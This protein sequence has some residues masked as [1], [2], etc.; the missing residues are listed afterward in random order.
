M[1]NQNDDLSAVAQLIENMIGKNPHNRELLSAFK[2][3]IIE[4]IRLVEGLELKAA[5]PPK[6]DGTKL[7]AGVP[8]IKQAALFYHDDPWNEIALSMIPVIQQGFPDLKD[9]LD[10]LETFIK[11][12]NIDLFDC[13]KSYPEGGSEIVDRWTA[14]MQLQ[15]PAIAFLI[16][17]VT[18]IIL[19]KRSKQIDW[20][21][22]EWEKGY[23]P[24]CGAFPSIAMIKEK[25]AVRWL[26]CSACG[27]DW[28]FDRFLCPY[29][30]H[31]GHKEVSYFFIEGKEQESAFICDTCKRYLVTLNRV[32]D[33]N[34]RDLDI[35]AIALIHMDVMM[36][37]KGF[38]PMATCE[39]NVF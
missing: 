6:I 14:E 12:G 31:E 20:Q 7:K 17:S 29:C 38:R 9:D 36:Q 15:A 19:E 25:I 24:V 28:K 22:L 39:W 35:F 33:L 21:K 13:F 10:K 26:H 3:F 1:M 30:E 4:R 23:C 34:F 2:P 32:S 11:D 16:Q 18:R 37:D 27:H 8:V 5:E